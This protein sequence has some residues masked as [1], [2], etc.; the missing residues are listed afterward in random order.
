[1][2]ESIFKKSF[3]HFL[4]LALALP[5]AAMAE[6]ESKGEGKEES[7]DEEKKP[8][9]IAELT[10][11][12]ER[13]DGYFTLFRDKKFGETKM[14]IKADQVG[15]E[16]LYWVQIANSVVE[17]GSFKGAY[18][19]S[20]MVSVQRHFNRIEFIAEN[21]SFYF[22]PDNAI[23]RASEANISDSLLATAKILAEDE[24][25]GDILIKA[26]KLFKSESLV[27]ITPTPDPDADPKTAF[28]LG[29]LDS[30]KTKILH[31]RSY[32]KNT[33]VEVEYVFSNPQPKVFVGPA[34]TDERNVSIRV[35]H[36]FIEAPDNDYQPRFDDMRMGFFSHQVTDL[37][38]TEPTPYRDMIN[39]WHLV[40]QD[41]NA[42]LSEPVVPI[43]WW[44][45]NTTPVEW[46]ELIRDAALEWNSAFEKAGFKNALVVKIQPDD[47]D[48][49]AGDIR[50]N[51]LRW[52]SS[53]NP[54]FGGY[55]PHFSDPRTGQAIGADVMLE[56]SFM[57]RTI[58]ARKLMQDDPATK[59]WGDEAGLLC[60]LG[61]SLQMNS[62]FV[63]AAAE[64]A[65]YADDDE[66]NQRLTHD[67]MH[68]LILHEI[69]HTLGMNHNMKATQFLS[70]EEA[71]DAE[72]VAERGL[73]GS[74]MDY[75]A[76]N[77][78][79]TREQQTQFYQTRPGPYDDWLIEFGYSTALDDPEA[80][81]ARLKAILARS[82]EPE[83]DFGNDA[84]DMRNA[85]KGLDP[86]VNIYD[87]STDAVTYSS[88]AMTLMKDTLEGMVN[89]FPDEGKS[90]EET[91]EGVALMLSQW[92]RHAAV[93]S[94]YIGG[95]YVDR[96]VIGQEGATQPFTPVETSRQR[97][98]MNVLADQV[99]APEAF[100]LPGELFAH[101]ARQRRGFDHFG[102]T[103]DPK[104]HDAVLAIQKN[105]LD[106]LMHPVVLKRITDTAL[107]G[108][109][110]S[111]SSIMNDLTDAVF[112]EDARG[113]VN[114][115]RQNLQ[116]EYVVRLAKMVKGGYDTPSQSMAVYTLNEIDDLLNRKRGNNVSTQAHTQNLKRTIEIALD[117]SA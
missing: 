58:R 116:M 117:T 21:T 50:Y 77:F 59:F 42:E 110:Y 63:M 107:Y 49:D 103:E 112:K 111:L 90:Y 3:L 54:P 73:A 6:E 83:L 102:A 85:G 101:A 113:N 14:L 86:R 26:D 67:T 8:K 89:K 46:R 15:E 22:D 53:P 18:G 84:D 95:V 62:A 93:V 106:H 39:R 12:S 87:M 98:A 74:V 69:G 72:V 31:L 34:V 40:K 43:L 33:D 52:T 45:E 71:F 79:P 80:E 38:S 61:H 4:I 65:G 44:I 28:S 105:A 48:W 75:P 81:A 76:V 94:R 27:Q 35:M 23:S 115:Q 96:A 20:G 47:A 92:N 7:K 36:S 16:F 56:F 30:D 5:T 68:Y 11:D 114:S 57:N 100:D 99:F 78:A 2:R 70:P 55:G 13:F 19:P 25:T 1:M 104:V 9:T 60:T 66:L 24:E 91:W 108:N 29:K 64:V 17:A 51:V 97:R 32:P 88:N 10:E 109:G 37:T 82:T 41:P